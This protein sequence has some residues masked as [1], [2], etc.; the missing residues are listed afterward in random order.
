MDILKKAVFV[1][2]NEWA[3]WEPA[4][5]ASQLNQSNLW[6]TEFASDV[7]EPV[8]IGGLKV[9][10]STNLYKLSEQSDLVV[11]IGGNSWD[12]DDE[13]LTNV[14]GQRLGADKK[15]AAICGAVD[16]LARGGLLSQFKHTGNAQYLWNDFSRYVNR[17]DFI[18]QQAIRD[19]NLVTANGTAP[20]EFANL[21]LKMVG[22]A[23]DD[24]INR[25]TDLYRMG[26]YAYSEKYGN[27][28]A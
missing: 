5:L 9:E 10:A 11:M 18:E 3:D 24:S 6:T 21:T 16:F 7:A 12:T 15:T 14:I 28:Y 17:D 20:L 19:R 27:P 13:R 23:D 2:R 8:S 1:L 25:T 22:L 4:Y 26:Y